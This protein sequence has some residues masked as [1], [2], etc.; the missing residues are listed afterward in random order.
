[1]SLINIESLKTPIPPD[2]FSLFVLGFRPFFMVAAS[3]AILLLAIWLYMLVEG[4]WQQTYYGNTLWHGHEML[5][6]F[7]VAVIAGFLLTATR[8]WTGVATLSGKALAG[9]AGLWLLARIL[10][11][12]DSHL[13]AI[14][15]AVADLAFL[16]LLAGA[17]LIPILRSGKRPQLIFVALLILLAAANLM[18]HLQ[19]L[20]LLDDSAAAGI[21]L[22]LNS[23][24]LII[25]VMAGRVMP[26]FIERG[27]PGS[28]PRKWPIVEKLA[29]GLMLL[30]I[31]VELFWPSS[32]LLTGLLWLL[33][34]VHGIRLTGW[35]G[36]Q[37]WAVPLL[38]VLYFGYVF[39][40]LGFAFKAAEGFELFPQ[41]TAI[42]AFSACIAILC[43]GMMSRVSLGHTGR[44]LVLARGMGLSFTLLILAMLIRV[45][46][47]LLLPG[48]EAWLLGIAA[49]FW[50]A[51]FAI[52]LVNYFSILI[53]A[54]VDGQPG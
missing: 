52:F 37:L 48:F 25:I 6:G 26:F 17:I 15:I 23:I 5:F 39:L 42:H 2:R 40:V 22:G 32:M 50:I 30:L 38:W 31:V 20:G 7:T 11:M 1:M 41:G 4:D 49:V 18:I 36:R 27:A 46:Q 29:P 21:N 35:S 16:P 44:P 34:I 53:R 51:A 19:V 28:H 54:R 3:A 12:L 33:T 10:P 45:L 9:L 14:V 8:N 13:P 43:L 24:L 47:P